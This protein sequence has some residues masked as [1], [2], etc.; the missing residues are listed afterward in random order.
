MPANVALGVSV[1]TK[2]AGLYVTLAVTDAPAEVRNVKVFVL[3]VD[4][5]IA[6]LNVAVTF[7]VPM[8]PVAPLAG[9]VAVTVGGVVSPDALHEALAAHVE[10]LRQRVRLPVTPSRTGRPARAT[11][12]AR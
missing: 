5:S 9:D 3:I 4:A 10:A 7:A 2:V 8:T 1:A 12:R 6:S 11:R